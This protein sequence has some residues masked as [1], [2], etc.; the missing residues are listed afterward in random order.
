M[1]SSVKR[2]LSI[3]FLIMIMSHSVSSKFLESK[4]VSFADA[5]AIA[6]ITKDS[7]SDLTNAIKTLNSNGGTIYINTKVINISTKSTIKLTGSK[8][9]GIVV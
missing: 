4:L 1:K 2:I 6:T 8:A 7:E 3:C 9:G 5:A